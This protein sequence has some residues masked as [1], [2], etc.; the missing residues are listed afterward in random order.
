MLRSFTFALATKYT[1]LKLEKKKEL[2]TINL[3]LSKKDHGFKL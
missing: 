2:N 1:G 3:L